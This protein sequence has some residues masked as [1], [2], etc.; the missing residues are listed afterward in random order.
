MLKRYINLGT[1]IMNKKYMNTNILNDIDNAM[2]E[3]LNK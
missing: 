3:W 1:G 2:E